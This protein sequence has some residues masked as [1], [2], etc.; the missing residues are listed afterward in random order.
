MVE[1]A[2]IK[3]KFVEREAVIKGRHVI[4]LRL[5]TSGEQSNLPVYAGLKTLTGIPLGPAAA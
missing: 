3:R 5:L 4:R 2:M 1:Q